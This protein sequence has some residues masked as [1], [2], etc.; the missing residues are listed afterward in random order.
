MNALLAL[1]LAVQIPVF[2][3]FAVSVFFLGRKAPSSWLAKL[4]LLEFPV[5]A[6]GGLGLPLF[7][8]FCVLKG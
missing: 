6:A 8:L 2:F 4:L 7:A 3:I 1:V 5:L